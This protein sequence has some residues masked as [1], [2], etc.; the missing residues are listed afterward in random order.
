DNGTASDYINLIK[1]VQETVKEKFDVSL[2][3]EVRIIGDSPD[4]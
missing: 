4:K 2:H 1:H 3:R